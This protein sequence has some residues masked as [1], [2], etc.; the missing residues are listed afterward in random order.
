MIIKPSERTENFGK[1][2]RGEIKREALTT[3]FESL[4]DFMKLS[5]GYLM[6]G[7]GYPSSGKSEFLDAILENMALQ[8]GWKSLYYSPENH[9]VEEHMVKLSE[10][11]IGTR[12]QRF[13]QEDQKKSL[14]FLEE[15]FAWLY[16]KEPYLETLLDLAQEHKDKDGLDALVIDPW[17]AVYH[18]RGNNTM[19]HEYLSEALTKVIRFG[20]DNNVLMCVI[21]HPKIPQKDRQG[22]IP[23]PNLYDI[24][25]GA[26]WRNKS[27]YGFVV[28]RP[29]M[30]RIT[31]NWVQV[32][33]NKVKYKWM[34]SVG[35][36]EFDYDRDSG[37]FAERGINKFYMPHETPP[38]F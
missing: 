20:R 16:P 25:D 8:Y 2:R 34:G 13:E 11:Y 4:D 6:V 9:P 30:D 22:N 33:I 28:H 7:T 17:N 24:S 3:G 23:V 29:D 32:Y 35:M 5:K 10:R 37:R 19:L 15:H 31:G 36:A 38:P 18:N 27:D 26:M 1:L 14:D 12:F 21:A